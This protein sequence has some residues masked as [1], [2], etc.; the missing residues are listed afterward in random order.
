VKLRKWQA[1]CV[2]KALNY[3]SFNGSHFLC[4]ATPGSGKTVMVAEVAARLHES[5]LI[6]FVL[7]F[8]PSVNVANNLHDTFSQ[9]FNCRFDGVIGSVGCSYT[10]QSL[11]FFNNDFWQIMKRNRVLVIFDEVHHW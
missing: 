1:E 8:S 7:C 4:L 11:L 10:Y 2:D 6:D 5:K 9:R 3:F